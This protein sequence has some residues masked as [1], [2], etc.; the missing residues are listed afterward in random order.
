MHDE[1]GPVEVSEESKALGYEVGDVSIPILLK[2][3]LGLVV[4]FLITSFITLG[5]YK[6]LITWRTEEKPVFAS[7]PGDMAPA[8]AMRSAGIPVVQAEPIPDIKDFRATEDARVEGYGT[9]RDGDGKTANY[10][11]LDRALQIL[12]QRGL[13]AV[14]A[15]GTMPVRTNTNAVTPPPTQPTSGTPGGTGTPTGQ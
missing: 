9:W 7:Q 12:E 11:P 1:H 13:P 14:E 5:I 6:V 8:Q 2:W 15:G 10:M 3:G 4:F